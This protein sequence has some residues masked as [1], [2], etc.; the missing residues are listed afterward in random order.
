MSVNFRKIN[1]TK[2]LKTFL[3][4]TIIVV[5]VILIIV[6]GGETKSP[7]TKKEVIKIG[8][9]LSLSGEA[10]FYGEGELDAIR[11]AVDEEN[12]KKGSKI[13][14]VVEDMGTLNNMSAINALRKLIDID[15][16]KVIIG[17]TWDM[18]A[19]SK[20]AD[21]SKIILISPDNTEGVESDFSLDYVFSTFYPQRS[22]L[23]A[24]AEFCREKDWD[25]VAIIKD[26]DIFSYTITNYFKEEATKNN[27]NITDEF[28]V[29]AQTS[30]FKTEITK[31]K[32]SL[33]DALLFAY[34]TTRGIILRQTKEMGLDIPILGTAALENQDILDDYSQYAEGRLVYAYPE[35]TK[36]KIEFL[37]GFREK[38]DKEPSGPV[39]PNAY[40]ATKIAIS[41]L[42]E[43]NDTNF[44]KN[45][46]NEREFDSVV[47][48]KIKFDEKGYIS[49]DSA[50]SIIKT[51]RGGQ[52]VP[53]EK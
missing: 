39:A 21:D 49:L 1:M 40:D 32:Q 29:F 27:I 30:D 2:L 53:Y 51:I 50:K 12:Q 3:W 31:L 44:I 37:N 28:L 22:E 8:A 33:P 38:Y 46:L 47:F 20:I 17:P 42:R 16:V 48:G 5:V 45:A 14:L 4:V 23:R 41:L 10:S 19:V 24:L 11:M 15:G 34:S 25:R 18:P 35:T 36:E 9:L 43:S 13:E 7:A 26:Q 6:V 52:F